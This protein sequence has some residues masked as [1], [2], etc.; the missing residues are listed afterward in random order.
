MERIDDLGRKNYKIIQNSEYFSF[1]IDAVL[2]AWFAKVH[3]NNV[4]VD[5]CSGNGIIPMLLEARNDVP[6]TYK[7]VEIQQ[8]LV[9]MAKRSIKLN[10]LESKIEAICGDLREITQIFE[11]SYADII[12]VNPPYMPVGSLQNINDAK[13][14]ARHEVHCT[15]KDIASASKY[16]LKSKG[17]VYMIHRPQRLAE[18]CNIFSHYNLEVKK[19]QLVQPK[20]DLPPSNVLIEAR[21]GA[22]P[23]LVMPKPIIVYNADGSYTKEIEDIYYG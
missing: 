10:G 13:T 1:G 7:S 14:I 3:K 17:K 2:L 18:I 9:N 8:E 20:A 19:I 11:P 22:K 4:C 23:H 12:T 21:Q 5:L 6:A 15:L 16:L